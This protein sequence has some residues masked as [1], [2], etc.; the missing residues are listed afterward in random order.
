[1]RIEGEYL[2]KAPREVVFNLLQDPEPLAKAM[3]GVTS[4]TQVSEQSYEV[5]ASLKVGPVSGSYGGQVTIAEERPPEHL[6]LVVEGSGAA[7]F[8]KGDGTID[9]EE[10][11]GGTLIHYAGETHVG[12][13]VAQVGQR[14]IQ[15]VARKLI[16]QGLQS[17]EAQLAEQEVAVP[18]DGE[19]TQS[20]SAS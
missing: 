15:S 8:L 3:P 1:M 11:P 20:E 13:R 7:G 16:A 12:G 19:P 6:H 2:F 10:V 14:L 5:Q 17:L 18:K 4:L 9:L